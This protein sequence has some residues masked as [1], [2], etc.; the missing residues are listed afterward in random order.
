M[1]AVVLFGSPLQLF[2]GIHRECIICVALHSAA[3][4]SVAL[5]LEC[6]LIESDEKRR[7]WPWQRLLIMGGAASN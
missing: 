2:W 3:A 7:L 4:L 6:A 5:G 1:A